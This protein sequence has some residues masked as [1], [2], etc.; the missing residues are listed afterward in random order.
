MERLT[1]TPDKADSVSTN[2]RDYQDGL[3]QYLDEIGRIPRLSDQEQF[4]TAQLVQAGN[5]VAKEKMITANLRLVVSIAQV[6]Q[7]NGLDLADL[8][9]EGNI[10]LE[11]ATDLFEPD[12]GFKFSTYATYWIR[13]AITRALDI[14]GRL[15][16]FPTDKL[17]QIRSVDQVRTYYYSQF[18][19]QP[20]LEEIAAYL[21][22]PA[23]KIQDLLEY[24]RRLS[25]A[26]LDEPAPNRTIR[27]TSYYD[28]LKSN[29]QPIE[30][31]VTDR[32]F[33]E[34]LMT[35]LN[36]QERTVIS[37]HF[38]LHGQPSHSLVEIGQ[39]LNLSSSYIARVKA[40]ALER[41]R[42]CP[43]VAEPD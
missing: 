17:S 18:Q 43:Q 21:D 27:R 28:I 8:I 7:H 16:C 22:Q 1:D 11:H 13:Q 34:E 4:E 40:V 29:D 2:G 19:R 10:G 20:N 41:M 42:H 9:Q 12:K 38:G 6:W 14:K 5:Q 15:I 31:S 26:S 3:D 33:S 32:L 24:R 30:Q 36:T 35:C 25:C 37:M 39:Y 23:N